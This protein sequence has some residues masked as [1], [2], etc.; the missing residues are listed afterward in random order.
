[1]KQVINGV[2]HALIINQ[3]TLEKTLKQQKHEALEET[4]EVCIESLTDAAIKIMKEE[5]ELV[6]EGLTSTGIGFLEELW[7]KQ[8]QIN[9][10]LRDDL[11]GQI[12]DLKSAFDSTM[13]VNH[14][15]LTKTQ[16]LDTKRSTSLL[17]ELVSKL[18]SLTAAV[19][20]LKSDNK[21]LAQQLKKCSVITQGESTASP[22]SV[23]DKHISNPDLA[24][25]HETANTS[26]S[27][28]ETQDTPSKDKSPNL[29]D[30]SSPDF[31]P[32]KGVE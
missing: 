21:A 15:S 10:T 25:A 27:A 30:P 23:E 19:E 18:N 24:T 22:S 6:G 26:N 3:Q 5:V 7:G 28:P 17:H 9:L 13:S 2:A 4:L 32:G 20:E 14:E 11:K 12:K 8:E 16:L 1:M 31:N 29:L